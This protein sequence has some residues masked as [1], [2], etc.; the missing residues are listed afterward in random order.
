MVDSA[1]LVAVAER[2]TRYYLAG[3]ILAG[4]QRRSVRC[5]AQ[6]PTMIPSQ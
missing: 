3:D 6:A 1:L 5:A 4:L 2:R